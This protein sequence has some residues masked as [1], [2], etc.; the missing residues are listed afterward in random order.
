MQLVG[1]LTELTEQSEDFS[2]AKEIF[3][4]TNLRMF[5]RFEPKKLTKRTV[6]KLAGDVVV[7]GEAGTPIEIYQ[8]PTSTSKLKEKPQKASKKRKTNQNDLPS[9]RE[10]KSLRN[11]SRDDRI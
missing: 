8:G 9:G 1:R 6:N 2:K 4:L 3:D 10:D 7:F 5:L 11:V